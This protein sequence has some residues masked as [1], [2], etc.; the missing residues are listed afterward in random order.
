LT[1]GQKLKQWR[2]EQNL[3]PNR[4]ASLLSG[5]TKKPTSRHTVMR[6]EKQKRIPYTLYANAIYEL[7]KG[8]VDFSQEDKPRF[9]FIKELK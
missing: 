4:L 7:T 1:N 8:L 3:S 2:I 9:K 6:W 5:I